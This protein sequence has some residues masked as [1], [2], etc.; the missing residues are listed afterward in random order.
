MALLFISPSSHKLP[1]LDYNDVGFEGKKSD[2]PNYDKFIHERNWHY[3]QYVANLL[4]QHGLQPEYG[5][6]KKGQALI[7]AA[8]LIHG[9]ASQLD[10]NCSRHSQVTHYLSEESFTY[11]TPMRTEDEQESWVEAD[12]IPPV[13]AD[14]AASR[15]LAHIH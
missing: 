3:Q 13:D 4:E 8:N 5:T 1:F 9:G 15:R 12:M 2:Y 6:I 10:K 7:W 11:H 14:D